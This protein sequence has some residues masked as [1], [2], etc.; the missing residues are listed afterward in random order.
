MKRAFLLGLP[1][2]LST[3]E[4]R[5]LRFTPREISAVVSDI[6]R[7]LEE[8]DMAPVLASDEQIAAALP[9]I[10]V[11]AAEHWN[12]VEGAAANAWCSDPA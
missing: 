4:Y 1:A 6:L 10:D 5:M 3:H 2:I 8:Q 9:G 7:R 12:A 11:E